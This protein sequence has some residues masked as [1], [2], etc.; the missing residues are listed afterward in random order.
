MKHDGKIAR[1]WNQQFFAS[2]FRAKTSAVSIGRMSRSVVL[3]FGCAFSVL[4]HDHASAAAPR[5]LR[6][7]YLSNSVTMASLWMAKETG[8]LA[9]EG[10]DIEILSMTASSAL[11]ALDM[12]RM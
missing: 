12:R 3:L 11:P 6:V 10:V 7:A 8:A 2:T 1:L 9:K 4:W 5:P